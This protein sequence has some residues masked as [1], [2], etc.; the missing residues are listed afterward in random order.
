[1]LGLV[2]Q[3]TVR[4]VYGP[5]GKALTERRDSTNHLDARPYVKS[6]AFAPDRLM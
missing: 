3:A 4:K 1:M 2:E 5:A 6:Q